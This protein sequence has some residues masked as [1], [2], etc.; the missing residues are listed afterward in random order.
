MEPGLLYVVYNEW[1]R[2]PETNEK[3][4]KIGITKGTVAD[5]YYG[6]DLKMPGKFQTLFAY[7]LNNYARAEQAIHEILNKHHVNGEWFSLSDELLKHIQQTCKIMDGELVEVDFE[8]S[9]DTIINQEDQKSVN[10]NHGTQGRNG[11]LPN[12]QDIINFFAQN[13]INLHGGWP[14]P[15]ANGNRI[16]FL[17][18]T[19]NT[20]YIFQWQ[21]DNEDRAS[22]D[23]KF[24]EIQ[25]IYPTARKTIGPKNP[26]WRRIF[27]DVDQANPLN[28]SLDIVNKTKFIMGYTG[29]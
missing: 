28:D 19:T 22:F 12:H 2:N 17:I 24:P 15:G 26:N 10:N 1:I 13:G 16:N 9:S 18:H 3:P 21:T 8:N 27:I 29:L 25:K 20:E 6:L 4:Y 23:T 5:R 14:N 11:M 7:K